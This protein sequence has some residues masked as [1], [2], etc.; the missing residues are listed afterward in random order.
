MAT[1]TASD[2]VGLYVEAHGEGFPLLLSPGYCQT[3]ENFRPQ[4]APF[5]A[6]D[7]GGGACLRV[8]SDLSSTV[9]RTPLSF[10]RSSWLEQRLSSPILPGRSNAPDPWRFVGQVTFRWECLFFDKAAPGSG[11]ADAGTTGRRTGFHHRLG[12]ILAPLDN[13]GHINTGS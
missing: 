1:V 13:T 8:Y 7:G 6:A 4:V 3:H 9:P 5:V 12:N 2:A 10:D 11:Q